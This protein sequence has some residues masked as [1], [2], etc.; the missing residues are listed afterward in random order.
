MQTP[1][2]PEELVA[3]LL[4]IPTDDPPETPLD[5]PTL[6]ASD[7]LD[8]TPDDPP[9]DDDRTPEDDAALELAPP[10]LPLLAP[11]DATDDDATTPELDP[12]VD[13]LPDVPPELDAPDPLP[14]VELEVDVESSG[15]VNPQPSP[16]LP[17]QMPSSAASPS[18]KH[19]PS[20]ATA[21][22]RT[23]TR[24]CFCPMLRCLP[25]DR[26]ANASPTPSTTLTLSHPRVTAV[27]FRLPCGRPRAERQT[28]T[29]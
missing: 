14:P 2:G 29:A 5:A 18:K 26:H 16:Q 7:V 10:L 13:V 28:R 15:A 6:D 1:Q 27:L 25:Q 17:L 9:T 8:A 24:H 4:L 22:V 3:P 19:P 23:Q 12:T 21:S 11:P 20:G